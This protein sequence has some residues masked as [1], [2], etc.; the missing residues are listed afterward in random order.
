M[1]GISNWNQGESRRELPGDDPRKIQTFIYYLLGARNKWRNHH[2]SHKA[3]RDTPS[4]EGVLD[5]FWAKGPFMGHILSTGITA[6][7]GLR[8][9]Q[10]SAG[11]QDKG[12]GTRY[13]EKRLPSYIPSF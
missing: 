12:V 7:P 2:L 5:A 13:W 8:I 9:T 3:A 11:P 4:S 10:D 6:R 1:K